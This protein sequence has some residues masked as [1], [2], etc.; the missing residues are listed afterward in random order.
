MMVYGCRSTWDN[1]NVV[2]NLGKK[3]KLTAIAGR[4]FHMV[5]TRSLKIFS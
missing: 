5:A 3:E 4:L 1:H 2:L